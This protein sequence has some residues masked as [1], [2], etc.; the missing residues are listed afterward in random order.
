M[1]LQ[2]RHREA[3]QLRDL[4]DILS[5][6]ESEQQ[7]LS[8]KET[9]HQPH[10]GKVQEESLGNPECE[11]RPEDRSGQC[12]AEAHESIVDGER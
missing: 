5:C 9:E 4:R 1:E 7:A 6:A 11:R 12:V 2:H 3:A 8:Q 10:L